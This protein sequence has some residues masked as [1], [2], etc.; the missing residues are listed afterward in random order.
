LTG[1]PAAALPG[2]APRATP[3]RAGARGVR[4]RRGL[5]GWAF[6]T[7]LLAVNLLVVLGP[8]LA[9][10]YY[11]LTDWSGLGPAT[12]VGLA[13]YGKAFG[14]PDVREALWHNIIWLVLFLIV[15]TV[16]G[17]LGAYL[18]GRVR[19]LQMVF[20]AIYF[21]PYIT[22]SVV[23]ASVWKMLLSPTSGVAYQ[24]GQ[25]GVPG[26]GDISFL[27]DP[28]LALYSVN[29]VVD[30]HFW[31]FTAVI[32]FAAMQG[33]DRDLY[34][35]AEV[36]GAGSWQQFRAVTLP[37]I[38]P[39]LVF[40]WLMSIIWTLKAFDYIYIITG[41]GPGGASDVMATLMYRKAFSEY[42]A[43]YAASLGISM[44]ILTGLVLVGYQVLRRRGWET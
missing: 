22:A 5:V 37:G 36:D 28:N 23:N 2:H 20:R 9:T 1:A 44:T 31:G 16:L 41:G 10:V 12:F 13:N 21:I 34:D 32:Y 18:L 24:L 7:P 29:F 19:K 3:P 6:L 42:E 15:P 35:A 39:T 14:D 40:M 4:W 33:V 17:L 25:L 8:S 38:R 27:G 30:W 11:S 26:V 43:G